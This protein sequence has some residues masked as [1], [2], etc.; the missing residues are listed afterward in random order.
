M[1]DTL[2]EVDGIDGESQ[3]ATYPK[4]IG[5]QW[6][7]WGMTQPATFGLGSGSGPSRTGRPEY[8]ALTFGYSFEKSVPLMC[9]ALDSGMVIETVKLHQ[10]RAGGKDAVQ[11]VDI[12]LKKALVVKVDVGSHP[13]G[14][15]E[16]PMVTVSMMYRSIDVEYRA[17]D[18]QGAGGAATAFTGEL[19]DDE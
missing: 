15:N 10:R 17:Q 4:A 9:W 18:A 13:S 2:I 11:M 3:D 12:L 16:L 6:W 5:V 14:A 1:F 7:E 8:S 19:Y